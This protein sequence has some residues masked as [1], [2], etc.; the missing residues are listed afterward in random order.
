MKLVGIDEAGRGALAGCLCVG[1]CVLNGEISGIK[2]SKTLSHKRRLNLAAQIRANSHYLI[3]CFSNAQIDENG[4][5]WCLKTALIAIKR[6]FADCEFLFDG[7]TNFGVSGIKTLVKADS[8]VAAV[9]AA[10]ILA[11][12]T[13]DLMMINLSTKY[14]KY[15]FATHKGYASKAHIE[16]IAK[17]GLSKIHRKSFHLKEL[18]KGLFDSFKRA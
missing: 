8:K 12:V 6:H 18:E 13:R 17:F 16:A 10:S 15:D 5:S 4:L 1:A 11:K 3:L 2:D 9:S 7:N 14:P